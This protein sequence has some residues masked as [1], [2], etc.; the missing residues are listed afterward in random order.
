MSLD[1]RSWLTGYAL[2]LAGNPLPFAVV[3]KRE[4]VAYLYNGVRLPALPEWDKEKY[5]YVTV[6]D[7]TSGL[8]GAIPGTYERP[9]T[10]E[11][12]RITTEQPDC[13][14]YMISQTN[15]KYSEWTEATNY[16]SGRVIWANYDVFDID[17][18]TL[19]MSA[20]DP[21]PVYE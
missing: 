5:P 13:L 20:S 12:G 8:Y 19:Y 7:F 17:G 4:P 16:I 6:V 14:F 2:G 11:D 3:E 15:L 1:L 18:V 21:A 10:H 9:L